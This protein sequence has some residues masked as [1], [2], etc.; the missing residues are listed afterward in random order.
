M[1]P[2]KELYTTAS[3]FTLGGS[4][5]SV[6]IVAGLVRTKLGW[7]PWLVALVFSELLA[8]GGLLA[9]SRDE[10]PSSRKILILVALCNGLL[11]YSQA[12]GLNAI[13]TGVPTRGA[14]TV[15][16]TLLPWLDPVPWWPSAEHATAAFVAEDALDGGANDAATALTGLA[17]FHQPI[18]S[19]IRRLEDELDTIRHDLTVTQQALKHGNQSERPSLEANLTRLDGLEAE[20]R[21]TARRLKLADEYIDATVTAVI[22]K[23]VREQLSTSQSNLKAAA[24]TLRQAWTPALKTGPPFRYFYTRVEFIPDPLVR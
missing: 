23:S 15:N 22:V 18:R 11:I 12:T 21:D 16:Q 3:L 7:D 6:F 2:P 24:T 10:W 8:F 9:L 4:S 19:E 13:Q 5:F 1:K 20:K 14:A 17:D